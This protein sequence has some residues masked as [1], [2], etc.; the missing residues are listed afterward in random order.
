DDDPLDVLETMRSR[1]DQSL[2]RLAQ[3][4][5]T[6]YKEFLLL[7]FNGDSPPHRS[8]SFAYVKL[9]EYKP[10][11]VAKKFRDWP[12][13]K[14]MDNF[15]NEYSAAGSS[16]PSRNHSGSDSGDSNASV[17][18]KSIGVIQRSELEQLCEPT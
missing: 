13:R 1:P 2:R 9:L 5:N 16:N 7:L 3:Y 6:L 8:L 12:L 4:R 14:L 15:L 11:E 18:S 10:Q 17:R